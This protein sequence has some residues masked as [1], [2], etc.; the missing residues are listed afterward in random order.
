[1]I[2]VFEDK[3]RY[4][5]ITLGQLASINCNI[6][7]LS[8]EPFPF[9]EKHIREIE[10]QVKTAQVMLVDGEMFSWYGSRLLHAAKYFEKLIVEI[11]KRITN[12][13]LECFL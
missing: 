7:L 6:V 8:S 1:M 3:K 9:K 10:E 13:S 5:E 11:Q 4:P 2:N 12:N